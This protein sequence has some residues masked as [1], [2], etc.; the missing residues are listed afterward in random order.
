MAG[1][2]PT[3]K[4]PQLTAYGSLLQ[5]HEMLEIWATNTSRRITSRDFVLPIDAIIT[6]TGMGATLPGSRQLVSSPTIQVTDNGAG[7]T[8]QLDALGTGALPGNPTALVGLTPINGVAVTWMRSD[9]APA[10]DQGIA[11]TWTSTHIFSATS[12]AISV[13]N[14][15][16]RIQLWETDAAANNRKWWTQVQGEQLSMLA[17]ADDLLSGNA[18]VVVDRTGIVIDTVNLQAATVQVNGVNVRDATNLFNTG[19]VPTVRLGSGVAD[20]TSWLRG[21]QTWQVLPGGFTGFA[22]PTASVG[23]VAVNGVATTAMRSDAAP[24]LDQ[25]IAPTWT[26]IH[27]FGAGTAPNTP[28]IRLQSN[29]PIITFIENDAAANNRAWYMD[30]QGEQLRLAAM[31]DAGATSTVFLA[32]DRTLNVI[33]TIALTSTA[34]TWNG[35]PILSTAT[36]FANPTGTVGLAV[37]NGVATTAMRSDA[38]PPLSQGIVPTW[39][40]VHSFAGTRS[41]FGTVPFTPA[42]TDGVVVFSSTQPNLFFYE[43]DGAADNRLWRFVASAETLVFQTRNDLDNSGTTWLTVDRTGITVDNVSFPTQVIFTQPKGAGVTYPVYISSIA[44]ALA[45]NETD[46]AANNRIWDFIANGETL[47]FRVA[48][49]TAA[50]LGTWIQVD[51]TAAVVDRV[52]FPTTTA[53]SF[54]VGASAVAGISNRIAHVIGN[55]S[56]VAMVLQSAVTGNT[57]L[58]LWNVATTGDNVFAVFYTEAGLTT[59][60]SISYNRGGGVTAYNTTSDE[61]RKMNIVDAPEAS[62]VIDSIRVR[63]FDWKES[64]VHLD[65]W[66]VAQELYKV[67]PL[68]VTVGS[69]NLDWAVDPAKLVPLLVKELQAVRRRLAAIEGSIH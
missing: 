7:S 43:S 66:F 13:E 47:S 12:P 37:V 1:P 18:W 57:C 59:R 20:A 27:T 34:L 9:A 40:G 63:S 44:P 14:V 26:G 35:N 56:T 49:D 21:D 62:E 39:T 16:P 31:D 46:A 25:A 33:D 3:K 42:V 45:L 68:A 5:G 60:G 50:S 23:L 28:S 53:G 8:V 6:L 4:I 69:E 48:D 52:T 29:R 58:D 2:I 61:R 19:T 36:A 32:V 38:A 10:L 11:P 51:R 67:A 17:M 55:A 64:G 15:T 41:V 65:H 30:V 54:L 24:A 22:N